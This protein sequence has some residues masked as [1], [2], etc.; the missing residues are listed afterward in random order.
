MVIL[1]ALTHRGHTQIVDTHKL[2]IVIPFTEN[3]P[4]EP[5]H[6]FRQGISLGLS[7]EERFLGAKRASE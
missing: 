2:T 5:R 6:A 7:I 4:G 3:A 1:L